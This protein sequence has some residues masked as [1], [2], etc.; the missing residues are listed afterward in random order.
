MGSWEVRRLGGA[1]VESA[2]PSRKARIQRGKDAGM[3]TNPDLVHKKMCKKKMECTENCADP[4]MADGGRQTT[5]DRLQMTDGG[6]KGQRTDG[7]ERRAE[8]GRLTT[9][10]RSQRP[11]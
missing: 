2:T 7:R 4:P 11:S 6:G 9:D 3:R 10:S 1:P 8:G 5:D